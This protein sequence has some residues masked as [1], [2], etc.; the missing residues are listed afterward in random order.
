[1]TKKFF[2][3]II[4]FAFLFGLKAQDFTTLWP[5]GKKPNDNGKKITDT[6]YNERIWRV[7]TPGIY[8]FLVPKSENTG[9]SVIIC[10]GGG[11]ERLSHIYNG[12]QFAKYF[13]SI[14]INVFVLIYRLPNQA[15]LI[16]RELAPL[17]DA[18]RAVRLVRANATKWN[19]KPDK[20]GVMGVSAGGHVAA[21]L[22]TH[23]DDVSA[24][25]DSLDAISF[26]PDFM[27]L[28]SPVISMGKYAHPGSKLR[29][30]G[31]DTSAAMINKYSN[32]LRVTA[33]TPPVFIV[34]ALNDSTVNVHNSLLFY[35]ALLD[36]K[37]NASL[38]IFPQGGHGIRITENPGSTNLWIELMRLWMKETGFLIPVPFK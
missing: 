4:C 7:A 13:N 17:Q 3:T 26:H 35:N 25:K 34:H 16:T 27:L 31:A 24:V 1:M 2:I 22:G 20:I 15:D 18:Q 19:L 29:F 10:P 37:V 5:A 36:N 33:A 11:Y 14:G 32:E 9:T 30:L 38:H 6:L 8:S 12:F 23:E 28:L 21:M